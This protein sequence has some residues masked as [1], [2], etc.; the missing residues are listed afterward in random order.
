M[1][2][3]LPGQQYQCGHGWEMPPS[4]LG[5]PLGAADETEWRCSR[6]SPVQGLGWISPAGISN[7]PSPKMIFKK[8]RLFLW[9]SLSLIIPRG[10]V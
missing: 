6:P 10:A 8:N 9:Q 4:L 5:N 3:P 1:A 7:P 2:K